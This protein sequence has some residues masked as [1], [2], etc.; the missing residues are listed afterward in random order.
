MKILQ[1]INDTWISTLD[2]DLQLFLITSI[3]FVSLITLIPAWGSTV[4]DV[5]ITRRA[6]ALVADSELPLPPPVRPER[7]A[8][9]RRIAMGYPPPLIN[10]GEPLSLEY[11]QGM[12]RTAIERIPSRQGVLRHD[13][14]EELS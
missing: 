11:F 12:I 3:V 1:T 14:T 6:P 5:G 8:P 10:D 7:R 4:V 13:H 9:F 2:G